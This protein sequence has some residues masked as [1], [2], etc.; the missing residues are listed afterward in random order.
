[1]GLDHPD[2]KLATVTILILSLVL[3]GAFG[4]VWLCFAMWGTNLFSAAFV[5]TL[6][7]LAAIKIYVLR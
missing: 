6:A 4:L 3:L 1:M 7:Y 5:L 2:A